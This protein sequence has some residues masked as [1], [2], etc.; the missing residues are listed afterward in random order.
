LEG[1]SLEYVDTFY[2]HLVHFY[3]HLV[4]FVVIWYILLPFGMFYGH[5]VYISR[6]GM[7]Y[8][9]N[10]ATLAM[11]LARDDVTNLFP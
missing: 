7:L 3:G 4:Y 8:R 10:L 2:G 5:L 1:L 9:E 6:F 11:H